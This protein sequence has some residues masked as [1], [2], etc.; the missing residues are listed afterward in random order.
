[1]TL[2]HRL[3]SETGEIIEREYTPDEMAEAQAELDKALKKDAEII[4]RKADK[5]S[6]L[7]KLSA[8]G[9]T[10]DEAAALLL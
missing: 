10:A 3:I 6:A 8:L 1:M 7:A 9:L 4:K 5:E 2:I